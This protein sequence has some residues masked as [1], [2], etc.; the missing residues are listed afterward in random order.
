LFVNGL[1]SG[2]LPASGPIT[3]SDGPLRIGGNAIWEEHFAGTI[4]EVRIYNRALS[5]SEIQTDMTTSIGG[6]SDTTPPTVSS[7]FPAPAAPVVALNAKVTGTFSEPMQAATVSG[8]TF[9]LRV[10]SS[11]A[12]VAGTIAYNTSTNVA[13]LT[14]TNLLV[15]GTQY[16]ATIKGAAAGVKDAAGN[17]MA[18]D[19]AWTF[20]AAT[21]PAPPTNVRIVR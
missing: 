9:E 21:A 6:T 19:H 8:T 7:V 10:V 11:G 2:A 1:P 18:A 20:T 17:G 16:R 14:P 4:D 12:L 3:A 15:N 13:T 5:Q